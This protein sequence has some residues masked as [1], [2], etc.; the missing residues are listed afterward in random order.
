MMN[1]LKHCLMGMGVAV[2]LTLICVLSVHAESSSS[3]KWEFQLAP[4]A[5]LAGQKGE[6]ATLPGLPKADI[7]YDFYDDILGNIKG[8]FMLVGEA[9]KGRYGMVL[10]IA[11]TDVEVEE[12]T[13][14]QLFSSIKS[15]TKTWIVSAAGQYRIVEKKRA[16]LDAIGG[17]RYW[18][19]DSK[20]SLGTGRLQGRTAS[21]KE[22]WV[23]PII[24]LKG[25][26]PIGESKFFVS[27]AFLL[28]G[29]GMGSDLMW[30]AN[31][32]L[33]YQWTKGFSTTVGYRYLDVDYEKDDF[34]YDVAQDGLLLGLSWRF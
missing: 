14:G 10:D 15:R 22:G 20:L 4:Y 23:D 19:V 6:V 31:A 18:S 13:P 28:G 1:S 24:G 34:L 30:D 9:R 3:D 17:I 8:A 25:L 27:G 26:L 2:F 5:W 7:D 21:N 32:N 16:F 33:G 29:F 11:Y 12:S